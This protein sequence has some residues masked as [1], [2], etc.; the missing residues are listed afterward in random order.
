MTGTL[1]PAKSIVTRL[2]QAA[3]NST[4]GSESKVDARGGSPKPYDVAGLRGAER[5]DDVDW[6]A[7]CREAAAGALNVFRVR[8]QP[9]IDVLC[10][11]RS[12]VGRYCVASHQKVAYAF[13]GERRKQFYQV[14]G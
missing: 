7:E 2:A 10:R 9:Q 5:L 3:S 4:P 6:D 14:S 12:S 13:G 1:I 8:R 11:P